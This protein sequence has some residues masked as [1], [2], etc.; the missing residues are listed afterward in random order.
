MDITPKASNQPFATPNW[1]ITKA[2]DAGKLRIDPKSL[3][4]PIFQADR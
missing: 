2:E 1:K 3:L 4:E